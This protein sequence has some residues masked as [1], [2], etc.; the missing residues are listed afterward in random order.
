MR[1]TVFLLIEFLTYHFDGMYNKYNRGDEAST[2][3]NKHL[4]RS[5]ILVY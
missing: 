1:N 3:F 2:S 5:D 4:F